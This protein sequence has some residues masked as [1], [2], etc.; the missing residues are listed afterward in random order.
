MRVP[1]GYPQRASLLGSRGLLST[2]A[3]VPSSW[4]GGERK[5]AATAGKLRKIRD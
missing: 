2:K 5:Q 4:A 1:C 3:S